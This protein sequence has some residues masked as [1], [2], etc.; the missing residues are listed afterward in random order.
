MAGKKRSKRSRRGIMRLGG[1]RKVKIALLPTIGVGV[2]L[3]APAVSALNKGG[4][5]KMIAQNFVDGLAYNATGYA[6]IANIKGTSGLANFYVPI[7]V[8][9]AAHIILS[10]LGINRALKGLPF[11][12]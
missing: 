10:K 1:H 4:G 9:S 6:P 8:G 5:L 3:A 12:L 7:G 2:A 11:T